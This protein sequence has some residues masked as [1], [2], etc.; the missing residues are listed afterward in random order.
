MIAWARID[1]AGGI[2]GGVEIPIA[3]GRS[4]IAA[5]AGV[6]SH[7]RCS[8]DPGGVRKR[9]VR[10]EAGPSQTEMVVRG[11]ERS[12]WGAGGNQLIRER[13]PARA[14]RDVGVLRRERGGEL[15]FNRVAIRANQREK[16]A[17]AVQLEIGVQFPP[18]H[19]PILAGSK[20]EKKRARG[21][22]RR[23]KRPE[24][25]LEGVVGEMPARQ[26]DGLG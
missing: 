20:D 25:G 3:H 13:F 26:V 23:G 14:K 2:G 7:C 17:G 9:L 12:G 10:G 11:N 18:S 24:D 1:G 6:V 16:F 8:S 21:E 5:A 22:I 15:R 19:R 4:E